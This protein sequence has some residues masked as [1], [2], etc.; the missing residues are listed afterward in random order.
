MPK[1]KQ[2]KNEINIQTTLKNYLMLIKN[3]QFIRYSF[4]FG[5]LYSGMMLW[6]ATSPFLLMKDYGLSAQSF[7]LSQI[8]IFGAFILASFLVKKWSD[9]KTFN[10]FIKAGL[11]GAIIA[12]LTLI[13][14]IA[15]PNKIVLLILAMAIY[16]FSFG[17]ACAPLN[18]MAFNTAAADKGIT[19]SAFYTCMMGTGSLITVLFGLF[20]GNYFS[21][22][23]AIFLVI[24]GAIVNFK[25][26]KN[27]NINK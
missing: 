2:K 16:A 25:E 8:P 5:M 4:C 22:V 19:A 18:R 12:L 23:I 9:K 20:Y 17:L 15:M 10:F 1:D 27:E 26:I 24:L 21:Y 6:I 3:K 14:N 11:I 13:F 7:G